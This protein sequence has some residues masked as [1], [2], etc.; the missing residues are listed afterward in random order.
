MKFYMLTFLIMFS[1]AIFANESISPQVKLSYTEAQLQNKKQFLSTVTQ[2]KLNLVTNL[3]AKDFN[4]NIK[5][6][7]AQILNIQDLSVFEK[8]ANAD[9]GS[10]KFVVNNDNGTTT[11]ESI[12]NF[13]EERSGVISMK[14]VTTNK[15]G[16]IA[17][18]KFYATIK[19]TKG[20]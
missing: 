13:E 14:N 5:Q 6:F 11:F 7:E 3:S 10:F 4:L 17:Y 2:S 16:T 18:K 20:N 9:H 12:F 1:V 19:T 15:E 8:Y